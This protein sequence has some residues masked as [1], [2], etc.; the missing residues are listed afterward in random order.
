MS[1]YS[2]SGPRLRASLAVLLLALFALP[3]AA[4]AQ[5]SP[6]E[7][8]SRGLLEVERIELNFYGGSLRGDTYLEL[9]DTFYDEEFT[10]DIGDRDLFDFSGDPLV[11]IRAPQKEIENGNT[12][13]ASV[14]F[15]LSENFGM[16]LHGAYAQA[17]AVLSGKDPGSDERYEWDRSSVDIIAGG[18]SVVY[19]LGREKKMKVRP[20]FDLGFGGIL[21]KFDAV[22]DVGALF[23]Q[24]GTGVTFGLFGP[25]RL[26]L[27]VGSKLF[28]FDTE[29]VSLAS[30]VNLATFSVGLTWRHDVP[31]KPV[32]PVDEPNGEDPVPAAEDL[33]VEE[34][35]SGR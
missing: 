31:P 28:T 8:S 19:H 14:T 11:N 7:E 17:D 33:P 23:F 1:S 10:F 21:T 3:L 2:L 35:A 20:Y 18:A 5:E 32:E 9:D 24:Y 6:E 15:Y 4:M 29:E 34:S 25:M 26:Q 13:G 30:T 27:G 12:Y 16:Q 22:D